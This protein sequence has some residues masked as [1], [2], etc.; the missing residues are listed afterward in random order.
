[1]AYDGPVDATLDAGPTG[2]GELLVLIHR[3]MRGLAPGQV[4]EVQ[5]Y[6]LGA[7]EDLPA[8][9]RMTGHQ[10]IASGAGRYWIRK[11]GADPPTQS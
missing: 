5:A 8:W 9:C 6:D 2:C 11:A 1:V 4:V 3:R 10:L 7:R